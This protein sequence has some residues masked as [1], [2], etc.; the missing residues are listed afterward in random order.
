MNCKKRLFFGLAALLCIS[1]ALLCGCS[2]EDVSADGG[3]ITA[4]DSNNIVLDGESV[5]ISEGGSYTVSGSLS[6]GQIVIEVPK[7]DKVELILDGVEINCES[8]APIYVKQADKVTI[9][10]AD[11]SENKLTVDGSF[12]QIDDNNIDAALFSKEDLE[13]GG[14]GSLVIACE[15]GNGITSKDDLVING[16]SYEIT[17]SGHAL[18]GKDLIQ[19]DDGSFVLVSGKDGLHAENKDDETLGSILIKSGSFDITADGDGIDSAVTLEI[20]DG[21]FNIVTGGGSVE[22]ESS[23]DFGGGRF[24]F[25]NTQTTDTTTDT[26]SQK[27]IKASG[28]LLIS[29]G[30]FNIDAYDDAVHTNSN[31]TID[32]GSFNIMTGDDAFHAD[33]SL[34]LNDGDI[35]ITRSYEGIE[36]LDITINGG[37]VSLVSTDDGI[38]AAGGND[39]SGFGGFKGGDMFGSESGDI[40]IN[41]G[42]IVIDAS[43]DGIDSN[44]GFYLNGGEVYVSGPTSGADGALDYQT[45]GVVT[46]GVIIA[47]DAG[48]MTQNFGDNSTQAAMLVSFDTT[49]NG[50]ILVSDLDGNLLASFTPTKEYRCA[51]ISLPGL[52]VGNTYTVS[53]GGSD[54][55]VEITSTI[56]GGGMQSWG[57]PGGN[58][59]GRPGMTDSELPEGFN[60]NAER[61]EMPEGFD[62]NAER[63]EMPEGFDPNAER[64]EIPEDFDTNAEPPEIPT[65]GAVTPPDDDSNDESETMQVDSESIM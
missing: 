1:T 2:Q 38:N 56:V 10:L 23:S 59:G 41:G 15:E 32:G 29:S 30:S 14:S 65:D 16:G 11:G 7:T 26:A 20:S 22:P 40:T 3:N 9:T 64:P 36:G 45:E 25:E 55:S 33:A 27:G 13:L 57:R 61:P 17:S 44:G 31:L 6:D 12:V 49:V 39:S 34:T 63:P 51:V 62:P 37:N 21:E 58:M 4:A 48:Q 35:T 42:V 50:E 8:S 43:G 18:E 54:I 47:T 19:I 53:G 28:D 52:E 60:P 46:G 5:M 24:G